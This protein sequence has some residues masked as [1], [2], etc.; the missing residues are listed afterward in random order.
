MIWQWFEHISKAEISWRLLWIRPIRERIEASTRAVSGHESHYS[1]RTSSLLEPKI[2]SRSLTSKPTQ[3]WHLHGSHQCPTSMGR[4]KTCES[5][6]ESWKKTLHKHQDMQKTPNAVLINNNI[7]PQFC[8]AQSIMIV[9]ERA[10]A[11]VP[12][13]WKQSSLKKIGW[14]IEVIIVR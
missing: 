3:D 5:I 11:S 13:P 7:R 8:S 6:F 4:I 12:R 14:R 9:N 2:G 10:C 1:L